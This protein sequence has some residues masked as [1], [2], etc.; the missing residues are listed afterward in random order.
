MGRP[1]VLTGIGESQVLTFGSFVTKVVIDG[2]EMSV[3]FHVIPDDDMKFDAILGTTIFNSDDMM[4]TKSGTIFSPRVL[5]VQQIPTTRS[6]DN[7][8]G[9]S[10]CMISTKDFKTAS[11]V[12]LERLSQEVASEVESV[13]DNYNPERNLTSP[14]EMKILLTDELPVYQHPR[15]LAYCDQKIVDDQVPDWLEEG[16]IKPSTSEFASPV[17]LVDKKNGK[18]RLCCDYR[19]LNEK[20]VRDNFPTAQMDCVI[21]KLQGGQ[22]FTTVDLTSGFF[23]EP[24]SPESQKYTSFVTQSGQYE[25]LFVPFGL[26]NSPAVFTRLIMAVI[27]DSIKNE[28][29]VVYMDDVI[30]SSKSIHEGVQKLKQVLKV[31]QGNGLRINWNKCQVMKRKVNFLG[32]VV[33]GGTIKPGNEKTQAVADF[34]I[35]RDKKG[36]QRFLGITLIIVNDHC[37]FVVM[38][39]GFFNFSTRN[40][41][42]LA[43]RAPFIFNLFFTK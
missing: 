34:P 31:A 39:G 30:I 12:D 7:H 43:A 19:K 2:I 10:T 26:T 3:E 36:V 27:R 40:V 15:R 6:V 37:H 21:E 42:L 25:F 4:V 22:V 8:A 1:G 9:Q 38:F 32:Y 13:I 17:V 29:A 33:E 41:E 14:V 35:P 5:S 16:I 11:A 24:V 23:H 28:D 18:K 20:I